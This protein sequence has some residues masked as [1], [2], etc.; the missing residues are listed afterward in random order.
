MT[1]RESIASDA[2][3][4]FL[5]TDDFAESVSYYPRGSSTGR[6]I[7]AVVVRD[8]IQEMTQNDS[9]VD[10]PMFEVHV[11]N[12]S[13]IGISGT[14]LNTGGDMIEFPTRD[15]MVATKHTILRLITQD[16]GMLVLECR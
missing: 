3:T 7:R 5:Q 12:D 10:L 14:E 2:S 4:I 6:S 11:A 13:S 16:H 9:L 15:G 1:L 8:S